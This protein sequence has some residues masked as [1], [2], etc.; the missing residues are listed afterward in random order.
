[1]K[2]N[3]IWTLMSQPSKYLIVTAA[4]KRIHMLV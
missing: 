4:F 1:M 3:W 2:W